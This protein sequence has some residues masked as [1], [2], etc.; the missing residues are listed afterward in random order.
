VPEYLDADPF[1]PTGVPATPEQVAEMLADPASPV[2]P[3]VVELLP[4]EQQ[5]TPEQ[6]DAAETAVP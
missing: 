6:I 5:P 1:I 2:T 4:V 3:D